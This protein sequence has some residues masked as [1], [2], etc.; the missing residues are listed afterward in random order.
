M[1]EIGVELILRVEGPGYRFARVGSYVYQ[2]LFGMEEHWLW[3][4][5]LGMEIGRLGIVQ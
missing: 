5:R 1:V 2:T 3:R 4:T